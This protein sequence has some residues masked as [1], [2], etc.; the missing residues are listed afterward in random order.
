MPGLAGPGDPGP[1]RDPAEHQQQRG[2]ERDLGQ[3]RGGDADRADRAEAVQR[4]RLRGQ[5]ADHRADHGGGRGGQ[6]RHG[7]AQ[8]GRHRVLGGRVLPQFFP[9]AVGQQQRV[10]AGRAEHQHGQ[11]GRG[12]RADRE[13][14][15]GQPVRGRLGHHDG[16]DRAEQR[17]Q[18]EQR[19]AVHQQQDDHHDDQRGQQQLG[20]GLAGDAAGRVQRGRSGHGGAQAWPGAAGRPADRPLDGLDRVRVNGGHI[21]R[22]RDDVGREC[23]GLAVGRPAR[24]AGRGQPADVAGQ[25]G[26]RGPGRAAVARSAASGR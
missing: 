9:V 24:Q 20:L 19:A 3:Q 15:A 25:P 7:A 14:G 6:G 13:P 2:Q 18:P 10:V 16:P 26:H 11:D 4:G 1:E 22:R 12:Q 8:R 23:V 5:Q 21:V 17:E